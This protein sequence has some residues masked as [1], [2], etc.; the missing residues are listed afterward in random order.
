MRADDRKG[1]RSGLV[2]WEDQRGQ[3]FPFVVTVLFCLFLI[4]GAVINVGQAVNR[5]IFLQMT[6]DAGAFT[7]ATEMARGL[8]TLAQLNAKIQRAWSSMTYAT[9]GFT[10]SPQCAAS[11]LGVAGYGTVLGATTELM[12]LV[13]SGYGK[14]AKSEARRVTEYNQRELFPGETLRMDESDGAGLESPRPKDRVVDL[15][16]VPDGTAPIYASLST[17]RSAAKWACLAGKTQ[18]VRSGLFGLWFEKKPDPQIAFVW[19]VKAPR[20]K[21]R[22]FDSF[23]GPDLIP[24]MTAVAA[25]RPVGGEIKT[26]K[27]QYIAKMIPVRNLK[28]SVYDM[29]F[30]VS[31]TV[32]H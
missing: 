22:V 19:V 7:G 9:A 30:R 24:E 15:R 8:N 14:R 26:A 4:A 13:N 6:A 10:V 23:F 31:R 18:A 28:G 16:Q 25:A 29:R 3:T 27:E 12:N 5:R 1:R 17:A 11:D 20:I 21:A 2:L 32:Q